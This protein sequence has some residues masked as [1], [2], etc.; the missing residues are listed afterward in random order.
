MMLADK[1]VSRDRRRGT[2]W[3]ESFLLLP[4]GRE[5]PNQVFLE[6]KKGVHLLQTQG[7]GGRENWATVVS[8][9]NDLVQVP[10][11]QEKRNSTCQNFSKILSSIRAELGPGHSP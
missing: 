1:E 7:A 11:C 6:G 10:H 2:R 8:P 4:R 9:S 5:T 3:A